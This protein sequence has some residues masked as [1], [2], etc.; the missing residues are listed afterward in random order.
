MS[1]ELVFQQNNVSVSK[2]LVKIDGTSYPINSI[3]SVFIQEASS[4]GHYI[5]AAVMFLIGIAS[6]SLIFMVIIAG[7]LVILGINKKSVLILRTASG[8]QQALRAK[9]LRFLGAVKS[10]IERAVSLRG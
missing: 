7:I 8:D 6:G 5:V 2:T 4:L 3:G 9:D 1:D 10:A